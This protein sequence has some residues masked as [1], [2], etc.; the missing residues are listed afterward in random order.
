MKVHNAVLEA[1]SAA[2]AK[3]K[4]GVT[5]A[6]VDGAARE[7]LKKY[8]LPVYGHGTGHGLGL[9]VHERPVVSAKIKGK[10]RAGRLSQSSRVSIC[11]VCSASASKMMYWL[12]KPAA[13]S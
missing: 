12:Q 13:K 4:D 9:E 8:K 3:V 1:Q 10:L 2:I 11:P 5:I 7:V 6:E